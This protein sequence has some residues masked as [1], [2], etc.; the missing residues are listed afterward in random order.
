MAK[1]LED[2]EWFPAL[3]R[4]QQVD[5][6]GNIARWFKIYQPLV[7]V[8]R[9]MMQQQHLQNITDCC[10][11]SG[12]PAVWLH[13]QL[14]GAVQT[15]LTDKFPQ[16]LHQPAAGVVYKSEPADLMQ[17]Q[18]QANHLYTM[19][20]AFHHF[21]TAAQKRLLQQF[22]DKQSPFLV[23]EIL[24]PDIAT[25]FNVLFTA[26]IGQLLLAPFVRPFSLI[27]LFFTYLLPVNILTVTY[28]GI[29]S[30]FK[31][32]TEAQY[33]IITDSIST[34]AYAITVSTAKTKTTTIIYLTGTPLHT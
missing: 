32:K 24:Q 19:Y 20:N 23:A 2:Y 21:D 6:I 10:S 16:A 15:V 4:R 18:P 12:E 8:L 3:L 11:G 34:A 9:Q 17:L 22:A 5:F 33:R 7:P 28:D 31:S 13:Q 14:N 1:E 29:V 30:V 25:F 27:R 26:T